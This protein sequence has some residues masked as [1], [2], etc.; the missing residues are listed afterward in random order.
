L[1]QD[2]V[3]VQMAMIKMQ[4]VE[5]IQIFLPYVWDGKQIFYEALKGN[6]FKLL[7]SGK[8]ERT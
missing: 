4:Q 1:I 3:E 2:W 8:N 7:S 5:F 6:G